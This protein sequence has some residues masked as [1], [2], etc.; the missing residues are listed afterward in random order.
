MKFISADSADRAAE[1]KDLPGTWLW[2]I[3]NIPQHVRTSMQV[4]DLIEI[5]FHGFSIYKSTNQQDK[6]DLPR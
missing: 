6:G 3:P 2:L 4:D 1:V 5:P